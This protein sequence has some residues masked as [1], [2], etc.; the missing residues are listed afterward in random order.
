[1]R[2]EN[3]R[4][5]CG[6]SILVEWA[7]GSPRTGPVSVAILAS[8]KFYF[9]HIIV[10]SESLLSNKTIL[11]VHGCS[12]RMHKMFNTFMTSM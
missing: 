5:I 10:S 12:F 7:K 11:K 1:M 9:P 8:V 3:G 2:Y 4:S 6:S